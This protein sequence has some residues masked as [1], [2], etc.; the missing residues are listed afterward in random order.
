MHE[1][2]GAIIIQEESVL[3]GMRSVDRKL[4]PKVWD[5]FGG[6]V[7]D[8]ESR[9]Q[10]LEMELGE[11]LGIVLAGAHYLETLR[12]PSSTEG[13]HFDAEMYAL[14]AKPSR[15]RESMGRK[16]THALVD[17]LIE[18]KFSGLIVC[19]LHANQAGRR[20]YE[21]IGEQLAGSQFLTNIRSISGII[22][23]PP[24]PCRR[25][26]LM[27][28]RSG[29]HATHVPSRPLWLSSFSSHDRARLQSLCTVRG[30]TLSTSAISGSVRPPKKRSSTTWH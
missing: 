30:E 16:L 28:K 24:N 29:Q 8:G 1:C 12:I 27:L 14:Y 11:E 26:N 5:V 3:P 6:H 23:V 4:Y 21:S 17:V 20:F 25:G 2:V 15:Q 18:R 19:V 13:D 9:R 10:A 7:E 22:P